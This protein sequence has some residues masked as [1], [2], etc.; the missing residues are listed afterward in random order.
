MSILNTSA[1]KLR[2]GFESPGTSQNSPFN[3]RWVSERWRSA[4]VVATVTAVSVP[5]VMAIA[6]GIDLNGIGKFIS[7]GTSTVNYFL[8]DIQELPIEPKLF[9][10][11]LAIGIPA[12]LATAAFQL[13]GN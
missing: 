8:Y 4:A 7:D 10:G 13:R 9:F 3:L 1:E 12:L 2:P 6:A 5:G 11:S